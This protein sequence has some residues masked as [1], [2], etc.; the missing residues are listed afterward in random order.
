MS[1]R[2]SQLG[3]AYRVKRGKQ[4]TC[5]AQ[6]CCKDDNLVNLSHLEQEIVHSRSFYDVDIVDLRVNLDRYDIVCHGDAL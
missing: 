2:S 4:P 3:L 6:T 5:L 1:Q